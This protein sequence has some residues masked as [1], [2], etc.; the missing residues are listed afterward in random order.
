M[1]L[2]NKVGNNEGPP[3]PILIT[4]EGSL[5]NLTL[6]E[7]NC[8]LG[9]IGNSK[10][11]NT[12]NLD[13]LVKNVISAEDGHDHDHELIKNHSSSA[14]SSSSSS[15][16]AN[17][18]SNNALSKKTIDEVW[19]EIVD[20]ECGNVN[21]ANVNCSSTRRQL[22][23]GE[24]TL[25]E[26]LIKAGVISLGNQ[27]SVTNVQPLSVFDPMVLVKQQPSD[28]LQFDMDSSQNRHQN[29]HQ[30]NIPIMPIQAGLILD[31]SSHFQV[32][33]DIGFM[34]V[35][36]LDN[37]NQ[38]EL[39]MDATSS[40]NNPYLGIERKRRFTEEMMEKS[41]QRRQRRMIKNRESAARS[42]AKKQAYTK[43]LEQTV[44]QLK[45]TNFLLKRRKEVGMLLD[46]N[47]ASGPL[48]QLRRTSSAQF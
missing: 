34:D 35:G 20:Q 31:D 6:D 17:V 47:P 26:F 11:L 40:I 30:V 36:Y 33:S 12:M 39:P 9:N 27:E 19:N 22:T 37:S 15:A 43:Q 14:S 32:S 16:S 18:K 2:P 7:I 38:M 45:E 4:Q 42:R 46:S 24:T 25:E 13:E 29:H 3:C 1:M 8:Q 21:N 28:W 41:I 10:P 44:L 48:Y 5:Y 23:L